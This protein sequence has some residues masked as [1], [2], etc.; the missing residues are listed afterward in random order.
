VSAQVVNTG[1]A[2]DGSSPS[3]QGHDEAMI[4]RFE[5]AQK[6]GQPDTFNSGNE[7]QGGEQ[8]PDWLPPNFKT[9]EDFVKSSETTR[10]ELTKAQQKLAE[11]EKG[12]PQDQGQQQQTPNAE[13]DVAREAANK[14][15]L[16]FDALGAKYAEKGQLDDTD[17]QALEAA[18]IPRQYVDRFIQGQQALLDAQRQA[19][20]S[21]VGGPQNY[22][23][24][25]RWAATNMTAEDIKAYNTAMDSGDPAMQK[26]AARGLYSK[27]TSENGQRPNLITGSNGAQ[28]AGDV[29][30]STA[31]LTAA[32][33]N[34]KYNTDPAYRQDV[35]DK[36]ARSQIM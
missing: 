28:S 5:Q 3:P 6:V 20:F 21:E 1:A 35:A 14:A 29:F 11:I 17:Y 10:A 32:M 30:R 19:V 26:N 18:N 23:A 33:R 13:Q 31:E 2:L 24:A 34:P 12:K 36:L 7:N 9:V 8:R 22:E 15:G 25:I 27:Y 4:Q 16:D